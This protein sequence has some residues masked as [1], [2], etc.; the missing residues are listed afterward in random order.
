[1]SKNV[2]NYLNIIV[3][4]GNLAPPV[5]NADIAILKETPHNSNKTVP[6]LTLEAQ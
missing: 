1:M 2:N 5:L 6:P 3:L 4:I